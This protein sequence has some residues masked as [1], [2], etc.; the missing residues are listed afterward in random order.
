MVWWYYHKSQDFNRNTSFIYLQKV[1][2]VTV[3]QT[4]C[5][6]N[7]VSGEEKQP[8][9]VVMAK[10]LQNEPCKGQIPEHIGKPYR[11]RTSDHPRP[12]NWTQRGCRLPDTKDTDIQLTTNSKS[13][14][15]C[16][17]HNQKYW[18]EDTLDNTWAPNMTWETAWWN[19]SDHKGLGWDEGGQGA[20]EMAAEGSMNRH[21]HMRIPAKNE[22]WQKQ[23]PRKTTGPMTNRRPTM[24]QTRAGNQTQLWSLD[25]STTTTVIYLHL[26]KADP[27]SP[28]TNHLAPL[29]KDVAT[30]ELLLQRGDV[31]VADEVELEIESLQG[32][33]HAA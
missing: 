28:A 25:W 31:V 4:T 5:L 24:T 20:M 21:P 9:R 14:D 2:K 19:D 17:L 13:I 26:E 23:P 16:K 27:A 10:A 15:V 7:Q 29:S 11:H 3:F 1:A 6:K 18:K 33:R 30:P 8:H 22:P 32:W 12:T